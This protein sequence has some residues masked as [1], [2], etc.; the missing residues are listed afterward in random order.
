MVLLVYFGDI[1]NILIFPSY[2]CKKG[3]KNMNNQYTAVINQDGEFWIG[4]IKEIPGVNCQEISYNELIQ[5]LKVTL[6]EAL[7]Y[8]M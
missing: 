1:C 7:E 3:V 4:W 5:T 8:Y 6:S 2:F